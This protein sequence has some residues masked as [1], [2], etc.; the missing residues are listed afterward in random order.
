MQEEQTQLSK[1]ALHNETA[2]SEYQSNQTDLNVARGG[3]ANMVE[4]ELRVTKCLTLPRKSRKSNF[5]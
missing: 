2:S 4:H 5:M 3:A 1:A